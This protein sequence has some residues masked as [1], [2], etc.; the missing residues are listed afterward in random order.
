MNATWS[1]MQQL[2]LRIRVFSAKANEARLETS[3]RGVGNA[4]RSAVDDQ[5]MGL[6]MVPSTSIRRPGGCVPVE[7]V[8]LHD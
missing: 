5:W 2:S 6:V 1:K 3:I 8:L 4:T 7:P